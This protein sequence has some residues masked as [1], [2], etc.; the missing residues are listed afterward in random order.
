MR[1]YPVRVA[2]MSEDELFQELV[3]KAADERWGAFGE[4]A[5]SLEM[6]PDERK[7]LR[8]VS[9]AHAKTGLPIFT[10]TPH[11]GCPSCGLGQL[12]IFESQASTR[13]ASSSVICRR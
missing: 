10:H 5:T 2:E 7:V 4:I 6:R 3:E 11:E 1:A 9:R 8:A 13:A 12:D